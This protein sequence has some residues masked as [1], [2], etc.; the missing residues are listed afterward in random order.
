MA[1]AYIRGDAAP[2]FESGSEGERENLQMAASEGLAYWV[3]V[4]RATAH[5]KGGPE[6]VPFNLRVT[7]LL[8]RIGL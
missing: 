1:L 4:R 6:T 7:E 2:N 3:G 5:L 8:R